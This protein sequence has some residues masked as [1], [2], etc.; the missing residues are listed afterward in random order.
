ML[1]AVHVRWNCNIRIDKHINRP[2]Y[3]IDIGFFK[4]IPTARVTNTLCWG[5]RTS[6]EFG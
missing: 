4:A 5:E 2:E 3:P 6:E 1:L